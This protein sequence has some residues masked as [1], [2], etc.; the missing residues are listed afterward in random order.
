MWC[1]LLVTIVG[2]KFCMGDVVNSYW[3]YL[4]SCVWLLHTSTNLRS[5]WPSPKVENSISRTLM[6]RSESTY[7]DI[8][9]REKRE[10]HELRWCSNTGGLW[11]SKMWQQYY[12]VHY[13]QMT[14]SMRFYGKR[15]KMVIVG[16]RDM[17]PYC[18]DRDTLS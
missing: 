11:K 4:K 8:F 10:R 17:W 5:T 15:D 14:L 16:W 12:C 2:L 1:F 18:Y 9:K 6:V 13:L 7:I 3:L